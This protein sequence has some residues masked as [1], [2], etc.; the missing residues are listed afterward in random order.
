MG[1]GGIV[2]LNAGYIYDCT[3]SGNFGSAS[4]SYLGGITAL[5]IHS[6][7]GTRTYEGKTYTT[8]TVENCSTAKGRTISGNATWAAS[9]AGTWTA[10]S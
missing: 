7:D 2:G 3:L 1:I 5:N 6:A 10:V 8:G 4:L 9:W